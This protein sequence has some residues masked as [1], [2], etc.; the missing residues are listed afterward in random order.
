MWNLHKSKACFEIA[1]NQFCYLKMENPSIHDDTNK[2][3]ISN[4]LFM[5]NVYDFIIYY[6][7]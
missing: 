4:R 6:G 2:N 5:W 1:Y 7:V 3:A